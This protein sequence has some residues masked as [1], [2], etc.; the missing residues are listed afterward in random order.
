MEIPKTE[1]EPSA[2]HIRRG[3][4]SVVAAAI[5]AGGDVREEV[6]ENLALG[7][8]ERRR[9]EDPWTDRLTVIAPTRIVVHRSRFEL[10]LNRPR[11]G[12]VYRTPEDAWGLDVWRQAEIRED[13]IVR[14]LEEYDRFYRAVRRLLEEKR[15]RYGVFV[16]YDL[17]SYNH[18]RQ[19]P[20]APPAPAADNPEV[21][22]GTGSMDRERWAPVVEALMETLREQRVDG[23]PL[24]VRENVRFV[25][26]HFPRW[27][28][29]TFPETG[30]APAIEIKKTF[31]DEWTGELRDGD[32]DALREALGATVGPVTRALARCRI[33][34]R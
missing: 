15:R 1:P 20:D 23:R 25:G 32:L 29:E 24:D 13:L 4:G 34:L 17:H 12:A 3:E 16:V 33:P 18:R 2:F 22:V 28:H 21:N 7:P 30:C 9:E 31:M 8:E 10:D 11:A 26:G 5:H 14:S 19:G 6:R 27:I